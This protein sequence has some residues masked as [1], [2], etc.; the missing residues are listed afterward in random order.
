MEHSGHFWRCR[1]RIAIYDWTVVELMICWSPLCFHST[2]KIIT[3]FF[4]SFCHSNPHLFDFEC[5]SYLDN[6]YFSGLWLNFT[7]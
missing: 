7:L 6:I 5:F 1:P 2:E 3:C 4:Y